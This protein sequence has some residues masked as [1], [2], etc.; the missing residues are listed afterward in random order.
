ME[1]KLGVIPPATPA[2]PKKTETVLEAENRKLW[3]DVLNDN[4]NPAQ[5]RSMKYVAPK[6][7]EG[8]VEVE[9]AE[10]DIT[11]EVNFWASSL[12][13]YIIGG[14]LSMNAL[15][16]YMTKTWNFV[17]L[18]D[19]YY[20]DEGYFILRFRSFS[21]R[22][23]VLMK[24]PYTYRNMPVLIREWML[25]FRL[26]DDFLRTL[27]IWIKLPQLPLCLWGE[28][29]LNKI[30]SA[31]G[32]PLVTDECTANKLRV[33][34]ARILVEMDITKDLPTEL[35]IRDK[36]GTKFLQPVEYEWKPMY[37]KRCQKP[38]HNCEQPKPKIKQWKPKEKPVETAI[39][40]PTES[41]KDLTVLKKPSTEDIPGDTDWSAVKKGGRD[42]GKQPILETPAENLTCVNGFDALQV[43]N[44]LQVLRDSG[45]Y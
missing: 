8:M 28:M 23:D 25:E 6:M 12:I 35:T 9:I 43:L 34:Y 44:D 4:R 15:K 3:V 19:M 38:G 31:L 26:K 40:I 1:E 17:Q 5:G 32:I 21:D 45:Q 18:P 39:V 29:S 42:R 36:D 37:C 11:S 20:N 7:V 16:N 27:P 13:L 2:N 24:G 22:D 30:G 14:D 10:E 33:S 41:L